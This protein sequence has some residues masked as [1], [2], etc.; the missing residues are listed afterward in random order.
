MNRRRSIRTLIAMTAL[1]IGSAIAFAHNGIEHVMGTV[2]AVT[3]TSITVDTVKHRS[4]TVMVDPSTTFTNKDAKA[5]FK[6]LKV[7]ERVVINAKESADKKLQG[8]SV[9]WGASSNAT[10][11]HADHKM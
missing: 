9:K 5:S 8:I 4:V 2:T 1:M 3:E 6:D 11:S 10:T 7:G